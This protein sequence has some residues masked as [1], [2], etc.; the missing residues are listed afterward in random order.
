MKTLITLTVRPRSGMFE[1]SPKEF[2]YYGHSQAIEAYP[3]SAS[4][5]PQPGGLLLSRLMIPPPAASS[6]GTAHWA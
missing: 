5:S 1:V 3:H 2:G 4:S 6:P